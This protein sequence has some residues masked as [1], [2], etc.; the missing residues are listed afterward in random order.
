MTTLSTDNASNLSEAEALLSQ[1]RAQLDTAVE[2]A[3]TTTDNGRRIDEHQVLTREAARLATRFEAAAAL[4][5]H[6]VQVEAT[7][8]AADLAS[9]AETYAAETLSTSWNTLRWQRDAFEFS[10]DEAES[11]RPTSTNEDWVR[12]RLTSESYEAAGRLALEHAGV[13]NGP[14]LSEGSPSSDAVDLRGATRRF[15]N[16]VVRPLAEDIHRRDLL[17]PD[18]LIEQMA[19]MGYFGMSIP[20]EHGGVGMSNLL[21]VVATEELSAAS[22]PAA[23]SLITR[24][25]ILSKALLKGGTDA[26]RERWLPAIASGEVMVAISVTEPGT[27]S[28]VAHLTCQANPGVADGREGYLLNGAKAWCTFAGR[29]NIL[30]LLARTSD[31]A[32]SGHSGLSLFIVEKET[33]DGNEFTAEQTTGGR[34]TGKAD[35]TMGY[36]GMH[37]FTLQFEDY[38]V[39]KENLVGGEAGV[40]KGFY[41]QMDGFAAGR[42][43]TGGRALGLA[44]ASM[45][46]ACQYALDRPQFGKPIAEYQNTQYEI[47][48]MAIRIQAARQLTYTAADAM[49]RADKK[50]GLL[51]SMAKLFSSR[52]AVD[53]SQRSQ[54]LHGGWGYAEEFAIS[55]Y[56]ADALVLPIFEGVEPILELKV[57]GRG[58]LA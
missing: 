28:D 4:L 7:E 29:A 47:G 46:A 22:L 15:A 27:G 40:G 52:A 35:A 42:L 6:A 24:P 19:A 57:I 48:A 3:R 36:R 25:E 58:I 53:I 8:P 30:A 31:D 11:A 26:Q 14:I 39:P 16:E 41:L 54:L 49:D 1:G 37:S 34:L 50:A 5:K 9:A 21:M 32:A 33:F 55:R 23:G 10:P 51:A 43:Q 56:V 18:S 13:N 2:K 44:Q 12:R 17:V 20:N 45:E 38:F